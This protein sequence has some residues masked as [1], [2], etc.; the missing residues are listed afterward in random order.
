MQVE[1]GPEII[2]VEEAVERELGAEE[3]GFVV[4]VADQHGDLCGCAG[5]VVAEYY[6]VVFGWAEVA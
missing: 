6:D 3:T 4:V 1:G 2:R 5:A